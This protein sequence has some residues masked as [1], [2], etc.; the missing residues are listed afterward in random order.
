MKT[1]IRTF[2]III[3]FQIIL[4]SF[5]HITGTNLNMEHYIV[6]ILLPHGLL[7]VPLWLLFDTIR[8][9]HDNGIN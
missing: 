3:I 6:L 5:I 8:M 9:E 1:Y 2:L 7:T 4:Y